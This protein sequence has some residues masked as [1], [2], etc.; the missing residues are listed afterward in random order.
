M[1][2]FSRGADVSTTRIW[3][4][5]ADLIDTR[6]HQLWLGVGA[7]AGALVYAG[8]RVIL[9][10]LHGHGA[11]APATSLCTVPDLTA[12]TWYGLLDH[13]AVN[14]AASLRALARR[15]GRSRARIDE[16]IASPP[17]RGANSRHHSSA[18]K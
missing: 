16:P 7:A 6:L 4:R 15:D 1:P 18:R 13:L 3:E 9:P 8:Y 17:P 10:D 5:A 14:S 2:I 12:V 11:S